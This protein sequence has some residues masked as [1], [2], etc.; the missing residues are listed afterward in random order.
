MES[1]TDQQLH[2]F[3]LPYMAP[4]HTLPLMDIAKLF[5]SRG[6][7]ATLVTTTVNAKVL[8]KAIQTSKNLGFEIELLV[9]KFPSVE[10]GLPDGIETSN[11]ATTQEMK[12]KFLKAMSL[13]E[14][15]VEQM[16]D[17][18]RPHF[19][20]ADSMFHWATDIAAKFG[21]PRLIFNGTGFFSMCASM[22]VMEYQPQLKVSSDSEPFVI[23]N[24][25]D[26][27]KTTR[28]EVPSFL[29]TDG[30][31]EFMKLVKASREAENKSYGVIVNSFYEL[32]SNYAD[33]YSNVIGRKA[34]H[35]GPV[36][37]C[38]KAEKEKAERGSG[39][40]VDAV[41]EC[42]NWLNSKTPKSVVYICFGSLTNFSDC[43]L[44]EI[45]LA[46]EA[47]H[48]QFIWVVKKRDK[49]PW[50]P[51]D[52]EKRM[53]GKGL[54]VRG[55]APQLLILEHEAVGAFLTHCGWNSILEGVCA[56]VPLITWPVSG[57]QFYNEKLVNQLLGIGVAVGAE[58]WA[59]VEDD[60][61]KGEASVK[62]EAIEKAVTEIMMGAEAERMRSKSKVLREMAKK[63]V[64]EGGSSFSDLTALV[65]EL[66]SFGS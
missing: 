56:G 23:P 27:I 45:A 51:E 21:I 58:K 41:H 19:L 28:N 48:Q 34:W 3:F 6:L 10:A 52:F 55:W 5:A 59:T 33:H 25:P 26:E 63:A 12:E 42:L 30:K 39:G 1:K 16:L 65:E 17:Q 47:S 31:T 24:L 18:H 46:L 9:F 37:L 8:S 22:S 44:L 2:I 29:K 64:V 62:R 36:S 57:E 20:V 60:N 4:G 15:K 11:S 50:L 14:P 49:E 13:I 66:S 61:V 40:S 35:I 43:Q 54:I 38:N 7:K 53:E 32:E